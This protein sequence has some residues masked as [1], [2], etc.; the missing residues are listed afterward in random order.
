MT[1]PRRL[2]DARQLKPSPGARPWT[3][4]DSTRL[5]STD[6]TSGTMDRLAANGVSFP[7]RFPRPRHDTA[8]ST[9][10]TGYTTAAVVPRARPTPRYSYST[11]SPAQPGKRS[12]SIPERENILCARHG[13]G[14][15]LYRWPVGASRPPG[16]LKLC[17][18]AAQAVSHIVNVLSCR[19]LFFSR[20]SKVGA[21]AAPRCER[22]NGHGVN[23]P[24]WVPTRTFRDDA[25]MPACMYS[26]CP[27]ATY[28]LGSEKRCKQICLSGPGVLL[29]GL[30]VVMLGVSV[31]KG[32]QG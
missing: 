14:A 27:D 18:P 3:R 12:Y 13:F 15:W 24:T 2:I 30:L 22:E 9:G 8:P 28:N 32:R 20:R 4:R 5:D 23:E 19:N 11:P 26:R 17:R 25:M 21:G 6:L 10:W 7:A 31:R 1:R 16:R 29:C